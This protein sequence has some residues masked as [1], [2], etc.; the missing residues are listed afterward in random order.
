[1]NQDSITIT[2]LVVFFLCAFGLVLI[3][4]WLFRR[5]STSRFQGRISRFVQPSELT[6]IPIPS[7]EE[8]AAVFN[9]GFGQVR[10]WIN[11]SLSI[12]SSEKLQIKISSAY[13]ALSDT[14]FILIRILSVILG[15]LLGW[16]VLNNVLGGIF[17]SIIMYI[18]PPLILDRAI[19]VRQQK[20][21]LQLLDVL[22]LIR[23]AV[24]AGYSLIQ[25]LDLAIKELT[26]PSSEEFSRVLREVRIGFPLEQA[27]LNLTERMES[28]DL[29]I[30]VTAIIINAQVGG[31]L[32]TVLEATIDTIRDRMHLF[33]EVRSL[34]SYARYVGNFLSLLPFIAGLIIFLLTP[35]Y[36]QSIL[37]STVTQ[38]IIG[39]AF[40]GVV[41]GNIWIRRIARVKV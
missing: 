10:T 39:F 2:L 41:L 9:T 8:R 20:F 30:V 40:V 27:L 4:I 31:N 6:D 34:T 33:G 13:W 36:F 37:D 35:D 11:K 29:Q 24:Q 22:V 25:A 1:L 38:V 19:A 16:L 28:D 26:P 12:L 17:L 23:G 3:G 15:F 5:G 7:Y 21:S 18:L 32:S 14:E